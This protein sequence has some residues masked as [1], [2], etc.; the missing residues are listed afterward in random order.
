MKELIKLLQV[1]ELEGG[2][3]CIRPDDNF[4]PSSYP[5]KGAIIFVSGILGFAFFIGIPWVLGMVHWLRFL[6]LIN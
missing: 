4:Q 2:D 3:G 1:S 5:W 6:H